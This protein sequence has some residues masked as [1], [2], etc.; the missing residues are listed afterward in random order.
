MGYTTEL[1]KDCMGV[2]HVG[3]GVVTGEEILRGS[4]AVAQLVQNTE[5]FH[6]EFVDLSRA[7]SVEIS[8]QHLAAI[9]ESDRLAAFFRPHA[10]V[11]IVAPNAAIFA[12]AK[13]WEAMVET[14]GWATHISRDRTEAVQWLSENFRP[15]PPEVLAQESNS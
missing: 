5:N 2:V 14:L 7:T 3:T 9:A 15:R 11:A 8:P 10:V 1:T 4:R 6:Y 13:Q 12:I